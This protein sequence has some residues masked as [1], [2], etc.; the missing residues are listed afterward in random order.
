MRRRRAVA[1]IVLSVFFGTGIGLLARTQMVVGARDANAA[2]VNLERDP[3]D[4]SEQTAI[5]EFEQ[6]PAEDQS[7]PVRVLPVRRTGNGSVPFAEMPSP[8]L[9]SR[10][11]PGHLPRSEQRTSDQ[12]GHALPSP[13]APSKVLPD[14][15]ARSG[16]D[17]AS[18]SPRS[19]SC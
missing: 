10:V 2:I 1:C 15:Q 9:P 12:Q 11:L 4:A 8:P 17:Q 13:P 6:K 7:P 16:S 14:T 19:A 18:V 3:S 5:S